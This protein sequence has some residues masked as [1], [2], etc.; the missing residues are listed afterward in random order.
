MRPANT[1]GTPFFQRAQ[2]LDP[3]EAYQ[4]MNLQ[5]NAFQR[6]PTFASLIIAN[7]SVVLFTANIPFG[8]ID[9]HSRVHNIDLSL[10]NFR[11]NHNKISTSV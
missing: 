9:S 5:M 4:D 6:F 11:W 3:T 10:I 2:K 7:I 1:R 8:V